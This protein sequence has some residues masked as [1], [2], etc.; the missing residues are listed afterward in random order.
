MN[1]ICNTCD[2]RL[3]LNLCEGKYGDFKYCFRKCGSLEGTKESITPFN[4]LKELYDAA[5][6]KTWGVTQLRMKAYG[7]EHL[8]ILIGK[9]PNGT[10]APIGYIIK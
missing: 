7:G 8:D 3:R 10:L 1:I 5:T 6:V 4:D 2:T 9:F